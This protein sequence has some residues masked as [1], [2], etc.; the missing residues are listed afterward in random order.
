LGKEENQSM[1][2]LSATPSK[3]DID[4]TRFEPIK[5]CRVVAGHAF[6][7]QKPILLRSLMVQYWRA[8]TCSRAVFRIASSWFVTDEPAAERRAFDK[9]EAA[10]QHAIKLHSDDMRKARELLAKYI[11]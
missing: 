6:E 2:D 8:P 5:T 11:A 9:M 10:M 7:A 1:N 4:L 3:A